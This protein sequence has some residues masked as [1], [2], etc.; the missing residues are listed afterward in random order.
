MLLPTPLA[1]QQPVLLEATSE[2]QIP[3]FLRYAG[4][5]V[6]GR[7]SLYLG[8]R[9]GGGRSINYVPSSPVILAQEVKR[10]CK[11]V[12]T[13]WTRNGLMYVCSHVVT[14]VGSTHWKLDNDK[15]TEV[16]RSPTDL[17]APPA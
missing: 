8:R 2:K 15:A 3:P 17:S 10:I 12:G 4:L 16:E 7:L 11:N 13:N 5:R 6:P 14:Y 9:A 1:D